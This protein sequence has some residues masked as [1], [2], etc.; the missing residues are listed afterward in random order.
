MDFSLSRFPMAVCNIADLEEIS[1]S[2]DRKYTIEQLYTKA[3]DISQTCY[4]NCHVYP[5]TYYAGYLYRVKEF[6]KA[7][8][9]WTEAAKVMSR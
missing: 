6:E 7:I 2:K 5:Y 1:P 8:V 9:I 4:Q 3:I